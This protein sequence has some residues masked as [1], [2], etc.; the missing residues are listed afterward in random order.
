MIKTKETK[1]NEIMLAGINAHIYNIQRELEGIEAKKFRLKEQLK[2]LKNAR[3]V[4][5][6]R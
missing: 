1:T 5:I 6:K 4:F 2:K 3:K